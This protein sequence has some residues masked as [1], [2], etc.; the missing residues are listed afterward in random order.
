MAASVAVVHGGQSDGRHGSAEGILTLHRNAETTAVA[1]D[2]RQ[3][4]TATSHSNR[5]G[6]E[7]RQADESLRRVMYFNC[8]GQG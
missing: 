6:D 5:D 3:F 4:S 1:V 7:K 2:L 8:W